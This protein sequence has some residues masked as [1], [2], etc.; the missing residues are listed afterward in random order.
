MWKKE[1]IVALE[2]ELRTIQD[3]NPRYS[4]RAYSKKIGV[5]FGSLS[6]LLNKKRSP[7]IKL[8]KK[9]LEKVKLEKNIHNKITSMIESEINKTVTLLPAEAKKVIENWH[10]FAVLNLLELDFS[11]KNSE[12]I[13]LRLNLPQGQV[14]RCINELIKWGFV[15]KINN[16]FAV[17]TNSWVTTDDIPSQSIRKA[18]SQGLGLAQ[19]ALKQLPIELRDITSLVFPGNSKQMNK[20]KIEIRKSLQRVHKIMTF[21][22]LDTVYKLNSQLF[23]LDRGQRIERDPV[24]TRGPQK[25][26]KR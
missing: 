2:K 5:G 25:K 11:P 18:H 21:G 23:P 8:A 13:S 17:N 10:Y 7:S 6:D 19:R 14:E 9:I 24:K 20:A 26:E 1:I 22:E 4:L 12:A 3:K 15:K 16:S